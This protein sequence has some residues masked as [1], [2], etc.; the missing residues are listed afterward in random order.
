MKKWSFLKTGFTFTGLKVGFTVTAAITAIVLLHLI[1]NPVAQNRSP[2]TCDRSVSVNISTATT[3]Q[4]VTNSATA[5]NPTRIYVCGANL[6]IVGAATANSVVF[7]Y[8][9]GSTCT[10]GLTVLTG[11][12]IGSTTVGG[13]TLLNLLYPFQATPLLNNL[14]I[15]TAQA[16]AVAGVISYAIF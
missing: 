11:P 10:T 2:L 13:S 1:S 9:T 4:V 16:T 6:T 5:D 14:C 12:M 3:T 8:G 15:V 7:E